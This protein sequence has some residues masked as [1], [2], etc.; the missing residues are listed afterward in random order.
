MNQAK[1]YAINASCSQHHLM[2]Y[3]CFYILPSLGRV[4]TIFT[5]FS[6]CHCL[7]TCFYICHQAIIHFLLHRI[8][9]IVQQSTKS[10]NIILYITRS[11][12]VTWQILAFMNIILFEYT[13]HH[14]VCFIFLPSNH[15]MWYQSRT[16]PIIP[17]S[18]TP[19]TE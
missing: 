2:L 6:Q 4:I 17:A 12:S 19:L 7:F 9:G 13:L 16:W 18:L 15:L 1:L 5:S 8:L 11:G 14:F 3:T 10:V